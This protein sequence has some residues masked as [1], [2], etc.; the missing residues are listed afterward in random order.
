MWPN[1]ELRDF[2]PPI[3][4]HLVKFA[5]VIAKIISQRFPSGVLCRHPDANEGEND[6]PMSTSASL[7]R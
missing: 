4:H 2:R 3:P 5:L 6:L 7:S 1:C